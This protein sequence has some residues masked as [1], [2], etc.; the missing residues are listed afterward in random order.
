MEV[1]ILDRNY[2]DRLIDEYEYDAYSDHPFEGESTFATDIM[3]PWEIELP[4]IIYCRADFRFIHNTD[5]PC[6]DIC[7]DSVFSKK[8]FD[9]ILNLS[10]LN[11]RSVPVIMVDDTYPDDPLREDGTLKDEVK[12]EEYV[13]VQLM[14]S[15]N[16]FDHDNS[17][18]DNS[19]IFPGEVGNIHKL[20]LKEP[21]GGFPSI[22]RIKEQGHMFVSS[23]AKEALVKAGIKGCEFKPVEVSS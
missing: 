6:V 3:G 18:Y 23:Q 7:T 20:V 5:Y 12:R 16:A 11:Y 9:V 21:E 4:K 22:F 19:H 15:V 13:A 2:Y 8:I 10:E 1:Y 17:E 14:D